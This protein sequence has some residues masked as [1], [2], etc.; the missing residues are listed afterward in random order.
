M[1]FSCIFKKP[2]KIFVNKTDARRAGSSRVASFAE[3][4]RM[5]QVVV[6]DDLS[7]TDEYVCPDYQAAWDLIEAERE[8]SLMYLRASLK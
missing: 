2:L 7:A 6:F 5:G 3:G 1:M 8:R 4:H